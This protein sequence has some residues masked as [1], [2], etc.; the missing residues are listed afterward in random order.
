MKYFTSHILIASVLALFLLGVCGYNVTARSTGRDDGGLSA[1]V[2]L[3]PCGSVYA[4]GPGGTNDDYTNRSITGGVTAPG[5][6]TTS[7]TVVFKNTVANV[8]M[9]DD[10]FLITVPSIPAGFR[11]ALSSDFGDHYT[12]VESPQSGLTLA[13]ASRMSSTFFVRV[14][15]PAG[16][17]TLTSH[18]IVLRATS[19]RDPSIADETIDRLYTSFI[20]LDKTVQVVGQPSTGITNAA[21]GS[22][23]EIIITYR[24]ISTSGGLGN[25]LLTAENLVISADGNSVPD[26]WAI[27][28]HVVGAFDDRGGYIVGDRE[29]STSLTNIVNS[30]RAGQAGVFKFRRRFK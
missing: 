2:L 10:T 19:V 24:N 14:T 6:L 22:L 27:T 26:V 13:V 1:G 8:G 11:V 28:D 20:R 9:S 18:D 15:T 21:P 29:G 4:E 25:S 23:L 17:E 7:A 16:L 12:P 30:L 3:G 5:S